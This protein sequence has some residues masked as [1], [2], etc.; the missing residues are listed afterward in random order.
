MT[1]RTNTSRRLALKFLAGAPML[2]MTGLAASTLLTGC[3]GGGDSATNS[4]S[5]PSSGGPATFVSASFGSM[6]APTTVANMATTYVASTLN[7]KLSDGST[8]TFNL[9][10]EPFFLTGKQVPNVMGGTTL[11]GGYY[12]IQGDPIMDE[13]MGESSSRQFFSDS[14]DGTTLLTVPNAKVEGVNN[15]VFAVVQFEYTTLAQDGATEMYGKLPSPIAVLTLDQD[16][17]TG[18]LTFKKYTTSTHVV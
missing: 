8:Q 1:N 15:P 16:V 11:A 12:N 4:D 17:S 18:K 5:T 10:Y 6:A 2:P 9:T 7:V 13:S 3:G 14:P